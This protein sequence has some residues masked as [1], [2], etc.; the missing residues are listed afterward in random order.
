MRSIKLLLS[1]DGTDFCGW[2]VQNN[3]RTVQGV[4]ESALERMHT[5]RVKVIGAGRTDSGVHATGQVAHFKTD[6]DSIP[7][8]KFTDAINS[9]LPDDVRV[10]KSNE[11]HHTFHARRSAKLRIYSYYIDCAP[12]VYPHLRRY[13]LSVRR[14]LDLEV[15]NSMAA[16]I[17]GKHDFS[18]FAAKKDRQKNRERKIYSSAFFTDGCYIIYRVVANS[19]LWKMVR[20]IVGTIP[21]LEEKRRG[22]DDFIGILRAT[23]RR[24]AG[25]TAPAKGL[26]LERVVYNDGEIYTR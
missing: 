3:D 8:R 22:V 2:Q 13:C 19:F 4:L 9:Y 24:L 6:L 20:N 5:H 7:D 15:L 10:L 16:V 23:D 21:G 26:F 1:Y 12:V 17:V 18:S 11:V 25:I 14:T